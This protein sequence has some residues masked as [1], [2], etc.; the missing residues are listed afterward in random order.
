VTELRWDAAIVHTAVD[1]FLLTNA[2]KYNDEQSI[3]S[4]TS[5]AYAIT[6]HPGHHAAQDSFGGYCYLNHA[7]YAAK[8]LLQ[9]RTTNIQKVAILDVDYHCGNG[10]ASIFYEDPSVL[11][12]SLHCDPDVEYPF[13]SGFA[14]QQ[15]FGEG[16]GTTLHVPLPP[17][18]TWEEG[19]QQALKRAMEAIK[20]FGAHALVISL[21]VDTHLGD[22]VVLRGAGFRL[23]GVDYWNMGETMASSLKNRIPTVI[24]QE[25]G[26]KMDVVAE[27]VSNV[28]LG[29]TLYTN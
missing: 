29:Y 15:G 16:V 5:V 12:V 18:T 24:I 11:V 25:G 26:Y 10:T 23:E 7:A 13:H 8:L 4:S 14:S 22:P 21:G 20:E 19:Y 17:G 2:T 3:E 9:S 1:T 28:V 6:T 27:A